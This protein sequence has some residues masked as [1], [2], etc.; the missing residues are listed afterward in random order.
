L[1]QYEP[2]Q[3]ARDVEAARLKQN[4]EK[5][6]LRPEDPEDEALKKRN[7]DL[8]RQKV[9]PEAINF[10][11]GRKSFLGSI[12]D[13]IG[14]WLK[15]P[16][17]TPVSSFADEFQHPD[18]KAYAST[19]EAT[20]KPNVSPR[21]WEMHQDYV[22]E[23]NRDALRGKT[24]PTDE[25]MRRHREIRDFFASGKAAAHEQYCNEIDERNSITAQ[26]LKRELEPWME[27]LTRDD[28]ESLRD[29]VSRLEM[30]A[31]HGGE[32]QYG[33]QP[34]DV[35][36]TLLK[37]KMAALRRRNQARRGEDG[38]DWLENSGFWH[39]G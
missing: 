29:D 35:Q 4:P 7:A 14:D 15:E 32:E 8:E 33:G 31:R 34:A 19:I 27:G 17:P 9:A 26:F 5:P 11:A 25:M 21:E 3:I 37:E 18:S 38:S 30:E 6:L 24:H 22:R 16:V 36:L 20:I 2:E 39:K 13:K 1:E 12:V 23:I 10:S 28:L